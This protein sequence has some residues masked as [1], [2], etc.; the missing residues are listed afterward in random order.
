MVDP[1]YAPLDVELLIPAEGLDLVVSE[2]A[3]VRLMLS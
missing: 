2:Y 1:F 3:P